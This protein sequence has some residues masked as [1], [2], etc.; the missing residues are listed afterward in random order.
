MRYIQLLIAL[1]AMSLSSY[2][3]SQCGEPVIPLCDADGNF[4]VNQDDIEAIALASGTP[5]TEPSDVRDIDGDGTITILDARQCVAQCTVDGCRNPWEP[6]PDELAACA[7]AEE[8]LADLIALIPPRPVLPNQP[9]TWEQGPDDADPTVLP[10][11]DRKPNIIVILADDMGF[12][13][14]S[15]YN[16]GAAASLP[17]PGIDDIATQG[18]AFSNGYASHATCAPARAAIMT[19]RYPTRFGYEFTPMPGSA[20]VIFELQNECN[21]DPLPTDVDVGIANSGPPGSQKAVPASEIFFAQQLQDAG[22]H[23][24]HIGKW[25]LGR[26]AG[27]TPLD[28]GFD[29]AIENSG[30]LYLPEDSPDV[31]NNYTE[32]S[33]LVARQ[34]MTGSYAVTWNNGDRMEPDGYVTDYFTDEAVEF[35]EANKNR[36]FFLHLSHWGVHAPLQATRDD[37]DALSHI[38]DERARVYAGMI[39]ALDRGVTRVMQ[40]LVDN[41]ID[42]NTL[43]IFTSD[44]GGASTIGLS[45]INAPYRGWKG[46]FFEGGTHVPY[47]MSWPKVIP[48]GTTYDGNVSHMDVFAT[49]VAAAGA[50]M[51]TGIPMDSVDLLPYIAPGAP[52]GEP[53][54]TLFWRNG[55]Y[56]SVLS[57]GWK[58]SV[59][60]RPDKVW[61][62]D[63]SVDP[64]ETNNLAD[65]NPAKVAELQA[66]IDAHETEQVPP[67][68]QSFIQGPFRVDKTQADEQLP[69]DEH[70]YWMN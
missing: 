23:T 54:D 63:L 11:D 65:A 8:E 56:H 13:D 10:P 20:A 37:Y 2:S 17:T 34:W 29:E 49:A 48:E 61:L 66:L 1:T 58:M 43:V 36:P 33:P 47:F 15:Y 3:Y 55:F 44:N 22:Y 45:D 42:N 12:N 7:E 27:T 19:G 31:V 59:S 53:H 69:T 68:W 26:A 41:G 6:T 39:R 46:T 60:D 40:A 32:F 14:V 57:D 51:P 52:T 50:S 25:H 16:G 5:A 70:V 35:I 18:V 38:T 64:L 4:E 67:L 30:N 28:K 24:G 9:V 62:Y 21:F